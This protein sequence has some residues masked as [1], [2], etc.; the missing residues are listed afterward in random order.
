MALW[1]AV[2]ASGEGDVAVDVDVEGGGGGGGGGEGMKVLLTTLKRRF[3][4][5]EE[6]CLKKDVKP[7]ESFK[8]ANKTAVWNGN[9]L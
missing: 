2:W 9:H 8:G 6:I 4:H 1:W 7:K 5:E 3:V